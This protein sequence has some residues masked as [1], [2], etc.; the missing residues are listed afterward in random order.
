M[1]IGRQALLN[2]RDVGGYPTQDGGRVRRGLL[3]RSS[4]PVG[5]SAGALD[6]MGVRAVFDLRSPEERRLAPDALP[7]DATYRN[8]D[9]MA[10]ASPPTAAE[11]DGLMADPVAARE[12]LGTRQAAQV[13]E[14]RFR[15]FVS[16]GSA[17]SG[18][19]AFFDQ[20]ADGASRPALVHCSTGKDRTG[21][22]VAALLSLLEV[23]REYIVADC[24]ASAELLEPVLGPARRAFV[25]RGGDAELF[26]A[27]A[28]VRAENLQA[29]F[30]E[31]LHAFGSVEAYLERGLGVG[32]NLVATIFF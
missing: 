1:S 3:Y 23:P 26:E 7:A 28:G 25:E 15:E 16:A 19:G 32:C 4:A 20:L 17:R 12:V 5:R 11:L 27:L 18:Y 29:A 22:A 6:E 8:E 2:L 10:D 31:T 13:S 30:V 14:Q 21:W 24:M 9:V